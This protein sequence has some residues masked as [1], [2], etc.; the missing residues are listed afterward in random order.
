MQNDELV[1]KASHQL[2]EFGLNPKQWKV[3]K[4]TSRLFRIQSRRSNSLILF[5]YWNETHWKSIWLVSI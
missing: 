5:G 1:S 4:K 3:S 2:I